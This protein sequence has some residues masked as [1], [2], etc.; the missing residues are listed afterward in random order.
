MPLSR[1]GGE[2]G[3]SAFFEILLEA[4]CGQGQRDRRHDDRKTGFFVKIENQNSENED[5]LDGVAD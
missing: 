2:D 1:V 3:R 5:Q 4:E